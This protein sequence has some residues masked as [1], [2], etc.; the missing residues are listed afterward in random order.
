M[1]LFTT[2]FCVLTML[3]INLYAE[4]EHQSTPINTQIIQLNQTQNE[5]PVYNV[6]PEEQS[7]G[8]VAKYAIRQTVGKNPHL[9]KLPQ[10]FFD[11]VKDLRTATFA[12]E[13]STS[14]LPTYTQN[15][16]DEK[17]VIL[18]SS[19]PNGENFFG[20][21]VTKDYYGIIRE[22][23]NQ[24]FSAGSKIELSNRRMT[25]LITMDETNTDGS[26]NKNSFGQYSLYVNGDCQKTVYKSDTD[27]AGGFR[28]FGNVPNVDGM[29]LGGVKSKS[30]SKVNAFSGTVHSIK[31]WNKV[32]TDNQCN[33]ETKW[34]IAAGDL[35]YESKKDGAVPYRIPAIAQASNGNI[36]TVA[37]ERH[38]LWDIGYKSD[39]R[40]DLMSRVWHSET[41]TWGELL[42][43]VRG[44]ETHGTLH[45]AYSDAAIVADLYS[46]EVLLLA[47]SGNVSYSQGTATNHIR[48]AQLRSHDNGTT[49]PK[50]GE[51]ITDITDQI[52]ALFEGSALKP[53]SMFVT[54]GKIAQSRRFK[55]AKGTHHRIYAG[56]LVKTEDNQD[57]NAAIYSDD[58]GRT[59]QLLGG[60]AI[61]PIPTG[62]NGN[63]NKL[64]ELPDGSVLLS[65]R[66]AVESHS[67]R[68][69][70]I[71]NYTDT[72]TGAGFWSTHALS[73]ADNN[74]T[75]CESSANGE[76]LCIPVVRNQ[77]QQKMYLMLQS[78]PQSTNRSKLV[79]YY[80][81]LVDL[82]DYNIPQN[83]AQN[84]EGYFNV[85]D[86][87]AAYSSLTIHKNHHI[88]LLYEN[89]YNVPHNVITD[90]KYPPGY[91]LFYRNFLVEDLTEGKYSYDDTAESAR[92]DYVKQNIDSKYD[93]LTQGGRYVGQST[94]N[95][96]ISRQLVGN[97]IAK[98]RQDATDVQYLEINKQIE[99][100]LKVT[101]LI[102]IEPGHVY[103]LI[104]KNT[105]LAF[106]PNNANGVTG[107]PSDHKAIDQYITFVATNQ[108]EVYAIKHLNQKWFL[109]KL[110][111]EK[112]WY[113]QP[114]NI[115]TGIVTEELNAG[116][117]HIISNEDGISTLECI[118]MTKVNGNYKYLN[119]S[120]DK[121]VIIA[122]ETNDAGNEW[123]IEPIDFTYVK[124]GRGMDANKTPNG[125]W[126]TLYLPYA[127]C[128]PEGV[129]AFIGAKDAQT[130]DL[131]LSPVKEAPAE[132]GLVIKHT[133]DQVRL[134]IVYKT[135]NTVNGNQLQGTLVEQTVPE[136]EHQH[137][138]VL[139]NG[140]H[141]LGMYWLPQNVN[142]LA[143]NKAYVHDA[144]H[145]S[146]FFA[147]SFGEITGIDKV[148]N[149]PHEANQSDTPVVYYD[150]SGRRVLNPSHGFYIANGRKVYIK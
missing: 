137:H 12:I 76:V 8:M 144:N 85:T 31:V 125:Y 73:N 65:S 94:S 71:F 147:F 126:S 127:V 133:A 92:L 87:E 1:R 47:S 51:D 108:P 11:A 10:E 2:L 93:L 120:P 61:M 74:G 114:I 80:K 140:P 58:F 113:N 5:T 57:F 112:N 38:G 43:I 79:I 128:I 95:T 7:S 19:D 41:Q 56:L 100:A 22:G 148:E 24:W 70:N 20:V 123:Y 50:Q 60:N 109:D 40:I 3:S 135:T 116:N 35:L 25:I 149:T 33:E 17:Q 32:L 129:E 111:S 117:Y 107:L 82:G 15:Q 90:G 6:T 48:I 110:A 9:V 118:N 63:E 83:L 146:R 66:N 62:A 26:W 102:K 28:I 72:E 21:Y 16:V 122:W 99:K 64:S 67:G 139:S 44:T 86:D 23:Q 4:K 84:W 105:G 45:T 75:A 88:G 98:Y 119:L 36:I 150:L 145:A 42:P 130:N 91:N 106:A 49:W 134:P 59:W 14:N 103:R 101:S 136:D 141:G 96:P 54:S 78:L 52:Y 131:M 55:A 121:H 143:P 89:G 29:Y 18:S 115:E 124:L 39:T 34:F 13:I 37:D 142:K 77:D 27:K 46:N 97:E 53:K 104:H 68:I 81:P 30:S 69:Y 138:Y 132:T